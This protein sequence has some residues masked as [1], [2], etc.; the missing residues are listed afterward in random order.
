VGSDALNER[1]KN[2]APVAQWIE[3]LTSDCSDVCSI[4]H[5]GN[6]HAKRAGSDALNERGSGLPFSVLR[7]RGRIIR[8]G[9]DALGRPG[10]Q[11]IECVEGWFHPLPP[12][13]QPDGIRGLVDFALRRGRQEPGPE[14]VVAPPLVAAGHEPAASDRSR[15]FASRGL[16]TSAG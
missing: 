14:H 6:G 15:E 7:T 9:H 11:P 10:H 5:E 16:G 12:C 1:G 4:R 13:P 3:H 8:L 2:R